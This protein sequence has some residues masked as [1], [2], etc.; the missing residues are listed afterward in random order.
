MIYA[1]RMIEVDRS[2]QRPMQ[3]VYCG[4]LASF[5]DFSSV[6]LC[7]SIKRI[8][9]G[10]VF[11]CTFHT[12]YILSRTYNVDFA[13]TSPDIIM[14]TLP[15]LTSPLSGMSDGSNMSRVFPTL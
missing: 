13:L 9:I 11:F 1:S 15:A 7:V 4:V 12:I 6:L 5:E 3:Q 2:S 8:K 14:T 10:E